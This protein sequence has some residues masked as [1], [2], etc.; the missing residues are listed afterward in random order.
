MPKLHSLRGTNPR[1]GPIQWTDQRR[2]NR[3]YS[4]RNGNGKNSHYGPTGYGRSGPRWPGRPWS[5]SRNNS[6]GSGSNSAT[7]SNHYGSL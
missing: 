1:S 6:S 5:L 7:G 3:S 4:S 2:Y